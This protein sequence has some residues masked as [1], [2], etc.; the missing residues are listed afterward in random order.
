MC[1]SLPIFWLGLLALLLFYARLHWFGG[2][3]RQDVAYE[4]TVERRTGFVLLDTWLSGD[5]GAFRDA[6]SH[7]ALPALVLHPMALLELAA[8]T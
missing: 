4:Y 2:P 7:I 3:G 8:Q 1:I 6:V 5:A